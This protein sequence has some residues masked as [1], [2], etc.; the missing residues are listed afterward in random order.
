MLSSK[1][2]LMLPP[3]SKFCA[4]VSS[5][6]DIDIR[7]KIDKNG[8]GSPAVDIRLVALSCTLIHSDLLSTWLLSQLVVAEFLC[9]FCLYM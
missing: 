2:A 3:V 5:Q 7:L 1:L 4:Q 6:I 8:R 9:S